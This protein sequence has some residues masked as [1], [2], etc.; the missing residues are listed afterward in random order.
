MIYT[1]Y[2]AQLRNLP[3]NIIPISICRFPPKWFRG[4]EYLKLAPLWS[5]LKRWKD[6]A[7]D[8]SAA[9]EYMQDF[10]EKVLSPL[11][12]VRVLDEIQMSIPDEIKV[13]MQSPVWRNNEWH[14][15]LVCYEKP[16]DFC[17]RHL[18]SQWLQD[19]G[20]ECKEWTKD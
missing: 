17:H 9:Q 16:N 5:T 7:K 13:K 3:T 2:F 18:V 1:T 10:Y 15:A 6:G 14:V 12:V 20:Y 11:S 19:S 4:L 8:Y